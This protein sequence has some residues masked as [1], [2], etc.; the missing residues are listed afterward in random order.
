MAF[1]HKMPDDYYTLSIIKEFNN[2]DTSVDYTKPI[3][4]RNTPIRHRLTLNHIEFIEY[5]VRLIKPIHF[6]EL[7]V[8]FGEATHKIIP[9]I[10]G[11]YYAVDMA[12]SE[13]IA[14]FEK[15]YTNFQFNQTTTDDYFKDL[16]SKKINLGLE[17]A[18]IDACHSHEATYRDFLNVKEHL[19]QD[20]I[21]IMHDMYPKDKESTHPD[22][23]GD[24]YKTAEKIRK[25]HNNEF[26][27]FTLPVEP[28]LSILRKV[29]QQLSWNTVIHNEETFGFMIAGCLRT[30]EHLYALNECVRSIK[31]HNPLQKIVVV[32]DFT[33]DS[34]FVQ[35]AIATNSDVIFELNTQH[36]PADML[37]LYY[38]KEKKYFDKAILLQDSMRLKKEMIVDEVNDI[39]YVWHFTN[40]R[41][42]WSNITEPETD[43]NVANNIKT[44]DDLVLHVIDTKIENTEFKTYCKDM[45][46]TKEKWCGCFGT[47]CI[48]THDFLMNL[49]ARTNII[50][51]EAQMVTNRLRRAIESVFALACQYVT[52]RDMEGSYDG[53][54]YNGSHGNNMEGATIHKISFD[55]Q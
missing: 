26:E 17:M 36:V 32:I 7:G 28:G 42:D 38:F 35:S 40:H 19:S 55:R 8:Q 23:S 12:R 43:Y 20:G 18:F 10:K 4:L 45:Y 21:I 2:I 34:D 54:Y 3:Y 53:L 31:Q 50:A 1:Q 14:Y 5:L 22:L 13:N 29:P 39:T 51:I 11:N 37:L 24:C 16:Q 9:H 33:S 46:F 48:I 25:N 27:I 6:I 49:D 52:Q 47:C 41:V 44:H 30:K 15:T